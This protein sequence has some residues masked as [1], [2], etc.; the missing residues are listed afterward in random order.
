ME[1]NNSL[2]IGSQLNVCT[3]NIE[4]ISKAKCDVLSKVL[5]DENIQILMLQETH[6]KDD[7][8]IQSRGVIEGFVLIDSLHSNVHG[9]ATYIKDNIAD[10]E[11]TFS[12]IEH[13]V[14]VIAIKVCSVTF[15]N[16]YKPPS[17]SW[18]EHTLPDFPNPCV[19]MG[20]FNSHHVNWGYRQNDQDGITILDWMNNSGFALIFDAKDKRTFH[21][22]VHGTET[23]PDLCFVSENLHQNNASKTNVLDNFP[24]TQHRPLVLKLGLAI[25]IVHS[26]NKPRWNFSKAHWNNF[27]TEMEHVIKFIPPQIENYQRFV[28]LTKSIAKKH[29]PRG[30]R[31]HYIPGWSRSSEELYSKFKISNNPDDANDLLNSLNEARKTKWMNQTENLDSHKSSRK[32]WSLLR[33]FGS[34]K[35]TSKRSCNQVSPNQIASKLI[36]NSKVHLNKLRQNSVK[37][38]LKRHLR[39]LP[40]NSNL[41]LEFTLD[42]LN[43]GLTD[44]K[45]GK[46]AGLDGIFPEFIKNF[47]KESKS[48]LVRFFN[49]I[50]KKQRL[51]KEFKRAKILSIVKPG[52]DGS[53]ASHYRPISLLSVIYKLFERLLLNRLQPIIDEHIPKEQAGFRPN[54]GSVEQVLA[55]TTFI[56]NGFQKNLKTFVIFVD[57]SSAYDTV[58]R[59]GILLKLSRIIPCKKMINIFNDML[60][61]RRFQIHINDKKSKWKLLNNGLPQG[62]VI[63]PLLFNLYI[64]DIPHTASK[65][66]QYADDLAIVYQCKTFEEAEVCLE[67]DLKIVFDYYTSWRLKPNPSKTVI[68]TFHLNNKEANRVPIV[69]FN[70]VQLTYDKTPKY[71]GI[72]LDRSLT[73]KTHLSKTALKV[74]TRNNILYKI[75][76]SNWGASPEVMRLTAMSL[77]NSV[78][79]FGSPVW[80]NSNHVSLVDVQLNE[81]LRLVSG[82][83]K[84]T[85]LPWLPVLSNIIPAELRRK[86]SLRKVIVNSRFYNNSI[87][88]DVLNENVCQ[89]LISRKVVSVQFNELQQF[90][91]KEQWREAWS[92]EILFNKDFVSDPVQKLNGFDLE[93]KHW[94]LLNRIRTGKGRCNACLFQWKIINFETCDCGSSSQTIPHLILFCP[95]RCFNGDYLELCTLNSTRSKEYLINFDVQL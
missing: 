54:R 47:Q 50:L 12:K 57:L 75:S 5:Y 2:I 70:D 29:I 52:K 63:A 26:L 86:D 7:S 66:F 8:D 87:L 72:T 60:S 71:L 20:D 59:Q 18:P 95:L 14:Y 78:G 27:S 31:K 34:A 76:G 48:W 62:S 10:Y 40:S 67:N 82:T 16:V 6:T 42:E 58:W 25:H 73:Y 11:T 32:F 38:E 15:V 64:S 77:I 44:V 13:G 69:K 93:R 19:Y 41:S 65:L 21:S 35:V 68:S 85:P 56:E 90:D 51:P 45:C 74:R 43:I 55:L 49:D 1:N 81:T 37:K 53:D 61:N 33:K 36:S 3:L 46:A 23:N 17:V 94:V 24:R 80:M 89:R 30:F 4:G 79:D 91:W 92:N 28:N 9:I 39:N 22:N 84:A 88:N 83:V